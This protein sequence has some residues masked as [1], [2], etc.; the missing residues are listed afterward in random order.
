M[1]EVSRLTKRL[2]KRKLKYRV[3]N[4]ADLKFYVQSIK[5]MTSDRRHEQKHRKRQQSC[6]N[7]VNMSIERK[8]YFVL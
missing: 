1:P 6:K 3:K 7:L 4:T 5:L 2:R 8:I